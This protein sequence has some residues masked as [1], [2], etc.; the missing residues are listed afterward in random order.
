MTGFHALF[1]DN[2]EE[3]VGWKENVFDSENYEV[4]KV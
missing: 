2:F 3:N 1:C 4:T